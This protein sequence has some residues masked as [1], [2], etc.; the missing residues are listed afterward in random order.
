MPATPKKTLDERVT[1]FLHAWAA[2]GVAE[3]NGHTD[4]A[5]SRYLQCAR[6]APTLSDETTSLTRAFACYERVYGRYCP[7]EL[8]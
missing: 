6:L 5:M 4:V 8:R 1:E 7:M 3:H 2:A